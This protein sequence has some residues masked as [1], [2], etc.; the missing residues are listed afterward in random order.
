MVDPFVLPRG[1]MKEVL[2][3]KP[4]GRIAI[5]IPLYQ[6]SSG[7]ALEPLDYF[8]RG[9]AIVYHI[10]REAEK[11]IFPLLLQNRVQRPN[12]SVDI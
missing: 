7:T 5:V 12:I 1:Y 10:P 6:N 2:R 3:M 8:G 4:P 11:V 9:G